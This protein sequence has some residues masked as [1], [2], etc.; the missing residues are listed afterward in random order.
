MPHKHS[1]VATSPT[2][3][4][5]LSYDGMCDPLGG[6]QVLPYVIGLSARGHKIDLISFEKAERTTEER[7]TVARICAE[8]GIAWHPLPYHKRPPIVSAMYD[9]GRMQRLAEHLHR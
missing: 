2:R 9:V 5:Y 6:S 8:A 1:G 4:L 3:A 7:E